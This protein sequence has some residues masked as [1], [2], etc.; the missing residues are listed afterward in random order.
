[1]VVQE[2]SRSL[3]PGRSSAGKV[4]QLHFP[5][6]IAASSLYS[7]PSDYALFISSVLANERLMKLVVG[8]PVP[9][10]KTQN[11]FWGLGWGIERSAKGS[12]LW[13]W[14]NN[15][16]FRALAM[17]NLGT[18]D[19]VVAMSATEAGMPAAKARVRA[20][21]PGSTPQPRFSSG[22]VNMAG[23]E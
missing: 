8:A 23:R 5:Y 7:T 6:E 22:A 12:F 11:V 13:H 17:A 21:L 16:G 15:P 20:V 9:V 4:H 3:V 1:M 2:L 10:P 18:K 19:A 14:G